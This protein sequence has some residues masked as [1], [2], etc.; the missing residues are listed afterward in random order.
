[1]LCK[2]CRR[3]DRARQ[4]KALCPRCGKPRLLRDDTGWCAFCSRPKPG[5]KPPRE[6][7]ECGRPFRSGGL[8]LCTRCYQRKPERALIRA[9]N[10]AARLDDPP[11]WPVEFAAHIIGPHSPGCATVLITELGRLL[12][13]GGPTHPQA[14]L[15]R[16]RTPGRSMGQLARTL[17]DYFVSNGL[18]IRLD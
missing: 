9:E 6:C 11:P 4:A 12:T 13:D 8:G 2:Q 17:E 5:P 1:V 15:E 18:A 10:L 14:L 16:A 3:K 7:A